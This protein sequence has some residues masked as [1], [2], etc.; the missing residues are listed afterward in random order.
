MV[1]SYD[2][3]IPITEKNLYIINLSLDF[4]IRN[5]CVKHIY[6]IGNLLIKNKINKFEN[7][8]FLDE[9]NLFNGMN[10]NNIKNLIKNRINNDNRSGW[11]F[12]QFLKMAYAFVS[13]NDEY[14]IW[15]ADTI[16][17]N[18]I[19]YYTDDNKL[20]FII[21]KENHLPYF[22]TIDTLFNNSVNRYNNNISFIAEN[23]IIDRNIMID[24]INTINANTNI[25]GENFYEKIINAICKEDLGFSGFSEFET[26]GNYVM[27]YYPH[28]YSFKKYRTQRL[29]SFLLGFKPTID[30]LNWAK[31]SYDIISFENRGLHLFSIITRSKFLRKSFSLKSIALIGVKI[32][33]LIDRIRGYKIIYYD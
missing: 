19:N 6:L 32:S 28:M 1:K 9:N 29:G 13:K 22:K 26:Y 14:V 27:T 17:L 25:K 33:H 24:M 15:D 7:V 8:S 3:I 12:Q 18:K 4:I 20:I 21:K 2:V 30:Q 11:Y 31:N 23:M 10:L 5:L 16:P